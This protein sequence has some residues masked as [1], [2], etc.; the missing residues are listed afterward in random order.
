MAWA[1][2]AFTEDRF[3]G[4]AESPLHERKSALEPCNSYKDRPDGVF[5]D[6]PELLNDFSMN[7][8]AILTGSSLLD[9]HFILSGSGNSVGVDATY[10]VYS[11]CLCLGFWACP[12]LF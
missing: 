6:M 4:F 7:V 12:Y 11:Q 8:T 10:G 9:A 3:G 5:G 1:G 2:D